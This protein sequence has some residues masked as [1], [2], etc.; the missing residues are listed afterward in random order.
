MNYL[1]EFQRD[2]NLLADGVIGKNTLN[3]MKEVFNLGTN[4]RTAHFVA[5]LTHESGEFEHGRE[6]MNYSSKRLGEVFKKYFPTQEL[7][8]QYARKPSKIGNKVYA[9]RMGNGPESSGDGYRYRGAF[10]IQTTGKNNFTLLSNYYRDREILNNT[11]KVLKKYYWKAAIAFFDMNNLF[12]YMDSVDY[13]SVRKLSRAINGGY[14]G[15]KKRYDLT[16]E[17]Y[18]IL[19]KK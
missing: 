9:N 17:Y 1:K 3:K 7:R 2:N 5:Q 12:R 14:N 10:S 13:N 16:V 19:K 6:N 18:N 8:D 15:L 4:E 11:D